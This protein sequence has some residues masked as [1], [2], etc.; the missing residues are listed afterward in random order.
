MKYLF[1]LL[2]ILT[3]NLTF[4]Q[5]NFP[6]FLQGTWK[7]K[8]KEIYEHWDKLNN[9]ALKGFS[10]KL[11]DEQI[12]VSEYLDIIQEN[13]EIFYIATV[14]NQNQGKGIKFKLTGKMDSKFIFKNS[15]HD[16][17]KKVVYQKISETEILVQ[18]SDGNQNGFSYKMIK[19][20]IE[21][22]E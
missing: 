19:Q 4:G 3:V 2:T 20:D 8:D 16:F 9:Q 14:L 12:V 18:V 21:K 17:P 15:N 22:T 1:I 6:D 13:N 11:K 7:V 5:S 10:Y